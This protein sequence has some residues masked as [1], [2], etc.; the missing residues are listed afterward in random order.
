M[1]K[2]RQTGKGEDGCIDRQ[3]DTW[4]SGGDKGDMCPLFLRIF[5]KNKSFDYSD[6]YN[7]LNTIFDVRNNYLGKV[8]DHCL[9]LKLCYVL[10]LCKNVILLHPTKISPPQKFL[11]P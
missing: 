8:L 2:N 11:S 1:E 6:Y 3:T 9:F 4:A 7:S 10:I 5:K